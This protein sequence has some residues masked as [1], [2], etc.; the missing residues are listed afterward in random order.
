M[1]SLPSPNKVH[2]LIKLGCAYC[3][4]PGKHAS[5]AVESLVPATLGEGRLGPEY[6]HR[7]KVKIFLK[8]ILTE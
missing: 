7:D 1:I 6:P 4:I 2:T 5:I 8:I 3:Y